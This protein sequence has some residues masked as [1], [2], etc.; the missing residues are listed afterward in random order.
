MVGKQILDQALI[1][2]EAVEDYKSRKKEGVLRFANDTLFF[3]S[4]KD[5]L[6]LLPNHVAFFE[7]MS[8]LKIN[9]GKCCI[10]G[11]NCEEDKLKRWVDLV[12]CVVGS[13]PS[14]YLGLPPGSY[15]KSTAL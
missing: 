10:M 2:N 11:I 5:S 6:F 9:K 12:G 13:L 8:G 7:E 1:A 14:S 15:P 3:C 4:R